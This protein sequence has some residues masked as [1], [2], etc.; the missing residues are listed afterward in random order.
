MESAI[1]QAPNQNNKGLKFQ[2]REAS[3]EEAPVASNSK[4]QANQPSQ[5]GNKSKKKNWRK[6]YSPSYRI[7][8]IQEDAIHNVFKMARTFMEFKEKEKQR[9]RQ[10][11]FPRK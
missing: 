3:N 1:I 8:K 5:E 4:H 10:P 11:H 2:N 7:T 9:M 6:P